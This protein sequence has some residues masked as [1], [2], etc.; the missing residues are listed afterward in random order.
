MTLL[1]G[2]HAPSS[3]LNSSRFMPMGKGTPGSTQTI[4]SPLT[5]RANRNMRIMTGKS[6]ENPRIL[7]NQNNIL[8]EEM[9]NIISQ[10]T[11]R[12]NQRQGGSVVQIGTPKYSA[13]TRRSK[14]TCKEQIFTDTLRQTRQARNR[15]SL[16]SM[17]DFWEGFKKK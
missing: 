4:S 12:R 14:R 8:V 10:N 17:N 7:S 3:L 1:K 13:Y 9:G 5:K 15:I 2:K 6:E 11:N 16:K